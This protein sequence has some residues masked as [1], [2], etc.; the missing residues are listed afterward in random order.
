MKDIAD[1]HET[2]IG[3]IWCYLAIFDK[4]YA[5]FVNL[6]VTL[7]TVTA[8]VHC[9]WRYFITL[10]YLQNL[11]QKQVKSCMGQLCYYIREL[12]LW[13]A[14]IDYIWRWLLDIKEK[15]GP[16]TLMKTSSSKY[17]SISICTWWPVL[18]N[19]WLLIPFLSFR[20]LVS[21]RSNDGN[22]E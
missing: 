4:P 20:S 1:I 7:F 15:T 17:I 14:K 6:W 9:T 2:W 12:S 22:K 5:T 10:C 13:Q 16:F 8:S 18:Y 21:T 19:I 11:F 3:F